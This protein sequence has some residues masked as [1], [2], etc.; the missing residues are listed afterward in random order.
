MEPISIAA[1]MRLNF[2]REI[3]GADMNSALSFIIPNMNKEDNIIQVKQKTLV[4]KCSY[5]N[6]IFNTATEKT[7]HENTHLRFS[8][9][10]CHLKF[11]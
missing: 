11:S 9:S 4:K 2:V 8:C 10:I 7:A 5:C 3:E 1:E 6:E